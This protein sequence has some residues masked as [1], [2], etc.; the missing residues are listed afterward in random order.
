VSIVATYRKQLEAKPFKGFAI[1]AQDGRAF[2]IDHAECVTTWP[3]DE[4]M[5]ILVMS[6]ERHELREAD[7]APTA[8]ISNA[9]PATVF[10][11]G[12]FP[13]PGP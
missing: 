10:Y 7:L 5:T 8:S 4:G 13:K 11:C 9:T 1:H 6:G 2:Q 12:K 3:Y